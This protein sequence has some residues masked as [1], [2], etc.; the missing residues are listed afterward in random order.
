MKFLFWGLWELDGVG[1]QRQTGKGFECH[2]E[3][4]V[5]Q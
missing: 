2:I 1:A 4:F 5:F 3:V